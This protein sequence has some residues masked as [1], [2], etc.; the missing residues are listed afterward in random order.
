MKSKTFGLALAAVLFGVSPTLAAEN[1]LT[2]GFTVS[3]TGKLNNN[4]VA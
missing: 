1:A 2:I 4:S 3:Q